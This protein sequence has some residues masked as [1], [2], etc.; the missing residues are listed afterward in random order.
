MKG[1]HRS[2]LCVIFTEPCLR[3]A[4]S[5]WHK[6]KFRGGEG[7]QV[8]EIRSSASTP[9]TAS[10]VFST[11]LPWPLTSGVQVSL[12]RGRV[13]GEAAALHRRPPVVKTVT[14]RAIKA[15]CHENKKKS[16]FQRRSAICGFAGGDVQGA[17]VTHGGDWESSSAPAC[18]TADQGRR[19]KIEQTV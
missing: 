18:A 15:L 7:T 14:W 2:P 9:L 3:G 11:P 12:P 8:G 6:W 1:W 13:R 17:W 4:L 16:F 19:R 10:V 5:M